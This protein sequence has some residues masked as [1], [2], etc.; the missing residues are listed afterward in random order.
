MSASESA[1]PTRGTYPIVALA[2]ALGCAGGAAAAWA[3]ARSR[4]AERQRR[5]DPRDAALSVAQ[6]LPYYP[7]RGIARFYDIDGF[8]RHPAVF[9]QVVDVLEAQ[10][11]A[12]GAEAIVGIDA[13]GF[14]LG[15]PLALALKLPFVMARKQGK[16]PHCVEGREAYTKEYAG[17]DRLTVPVGSVRKGQRIVI[18]DDLV[19]TGGTVKAALDLCERDLGAVCLGVAC[20]VEIKALGARARLVAAGYSRVADGILAVVDEAHLHLDGTAAKTK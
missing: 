3:L 7:F 12:L 14:I 17:E 16:L 6:V 10:C 9:Q 19:A 4:A 15:A 11:A 18:V 1:P 5:V 13:R 2:A 8:L 20:V